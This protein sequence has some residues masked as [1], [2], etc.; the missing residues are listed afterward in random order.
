MHLDIP[1]ESAHGCFCG[2]RNCFFSFK[3]YNTYNKL[4]ETN[5]SY[6]VLKNWFLLYLKYLNIKKC[7]KPKPPCGIINIL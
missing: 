4:K 3:H 6:G 7:K 1:L 5:V 2:A